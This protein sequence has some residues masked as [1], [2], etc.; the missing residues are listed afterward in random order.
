MGDFVVVVR[1][2]DYCHGAAL[3]QQNLLRTLSRSRTEATYRVE[4]NIPQMPINT[5]QTAD[6]SRGI[7]GL[8]HDEQ[9]SRL[10]AKLKRELGD[11]V[12][13]LLDDGA[14]EDIVLNP[15]STL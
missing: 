9:H 5:T 12:L 14:T 11:T 2:G 10:E 3:G 4:G 15:D 7:P 13:E 1:D 8:A 6:R